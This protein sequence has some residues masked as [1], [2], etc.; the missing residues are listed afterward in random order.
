MAV[1]A[2][3]ARADAGDNRPVTNRETAHRRADLD[4]VPTPSCPSTRPRSPP[5]RL[6][7]GCAGRSRRWSSC[8]LHD[9]VGGRLI[10]GSGTVSHAFSPGPWYTSAFMDA[11]IPQVPLRDGGACQRGPTAIRSPQLSHHRAAAHAPHL[12]TARMRGQIATD[13]AR[14]AVPSREGRLVA[15]R[16]VGRRRLTGATGTSVGVADTNED[17]PRSRSLRVAPGSLGSTPSPPQAMRHQH[18]MWRSQRTPAVGRRSGGLQDLQRPPRPLSLR[19][20]DTGPT[21][22]ARLSP[23]PGCT[24]RSAA[25]TS[26]PQL[27]RSAVVGTD[28]AGR[29]PVSFSRTLEEL[30]SDGEHLAAHPVNRHDAP[31][32]PRYELAW[33]GGR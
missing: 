16:E 24:R 20:L 14:V 8:R 3:A 22:S 5:G 9:H 26:R 30:R 7:S 28:A 21:R 27:I 23:I 11:S 1:R 15:A 12:L 31:A 10:V 25:R 18:K 4:Q 13:G 2:R 29:Q 17:A 32:Q 19:P 33:R 6:P